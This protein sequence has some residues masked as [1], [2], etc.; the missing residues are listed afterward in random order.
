MSGLVQ[1]IMPA[2]M[3]S[4]LDNPVDNSGFQILTCRK[5]SRYAETNNSGLYQRTK[6]VGNKV[7][8]P[9]SPA[10]KNEIIGLEPVYTL[11]NENSYMDEDQKLEP[12]VL[13]ALNG[14]P[15][16]SAK[17]VDR[18]IRWL[19]FAR[20]ETA[21][22][23]VPGN[24]NGGIVVIAQGVLTVMHSGVRTISAGALV[25]LRAPTEDEA[26]MQ[27][28]TGRSQG[29]AIG[30]LEEYKPHLDSMD[31][32][33]GFMSLMRD[34]KQPLQPRAERELSE[35]QS[36]AFRLWWRSQRT[37]IVVALASFTLADGTA[38]D[39]KFRKDLKTIATAFGLIG[40]ETSKSLK[41]Q[42]DLLQRVFVRKIFAGGVADEDDAGQLLF[43]LENSMNADRDADDLD[44]ARMQKSAVENNFNAIIGAHSRRITSIIGRT[45]TGGKPGG[46]ID[47]AFKGTS[48]P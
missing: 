28:F 1:P 11:E 22:E 17:A 2:P 27:I 47:I 5:G 13:S 16:N 33:N 18:I 40:N 29:K 37:I 48:G 42:V 14:L 26:T 24:A 43:D 39:D 8:G 9:I 20:D 21:N 44:L 45:S 46:S 19:G 10:I 7:I 15:A 35:D 30:L 23:H 6:K 31:A 12:P 4:P 25:C 36:E 34:L 41:F 3:P 38:Q 32:F